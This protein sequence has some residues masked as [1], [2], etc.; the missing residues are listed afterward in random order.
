MVI[1]M[2]G[3]FVRCAVASGAK[4]IVIEGFGRGNVTPSVLDA[5]RE[6]ISA[7]VLVF[8]ASRC[9]QGRARP[10]YGGPGGGRELERAGAIFVG[11]LSGPKARVLAAVLLG[12]SMEA[13][14]I[15]RVFSYFG[16]DNGA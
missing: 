15:R 1:G 3:R 10:I 7:G 9:T 16:G 13:V 5:I 11:D 14:E 8:I 6:S 12:C 2:D 4:A